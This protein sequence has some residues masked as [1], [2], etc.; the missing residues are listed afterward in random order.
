MALDK[1]DKYLEY[2]SSSKLLLLTNILIFM[3]F[4]IFGDA[5]EPQKLIV[6]IIALVLCFVAVYAAKIAVN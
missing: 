3:A 1:F 4:F 5:K 2:A 6:D